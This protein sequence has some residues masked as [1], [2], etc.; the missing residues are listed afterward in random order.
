MLKRPL[1]RMF[2]A[3]CEEGVVGS[4]VQL[5]LPQPA[6]PHQAQVTDHSST[7]LLVPEGLETKGKSL[8][9]SVLAPGQ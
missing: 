6:Y 1:L 8:E 7:Y 9:N 5:P 4:I 2:I 3:T